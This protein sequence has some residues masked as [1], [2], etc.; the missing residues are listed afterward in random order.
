MCIL[1][2]ENAKQFGEELE[3]WPVEEMLEELLKGDEIG[4]CSAWCFVRSLHWSRSLC[5]CA[6]CC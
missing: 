3:D 1:S 6:V 4:S 2:Q 5:S